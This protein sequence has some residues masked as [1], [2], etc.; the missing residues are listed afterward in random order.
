MIFGQQHIEKK[1]YA[2]GNVSQKG[3]D[4]N[5]FVHDITF[6]KGVEIVI[7][8]NFCMI[9]SRVKEQT[10]VYFV[11]VKCESEKFKDKT[12]FMDC[13]LNCVLAKKVKNC[14]VTPS[15][16]IYAIGKREKVINPE[17]IIDGKYAGAI[18]ELGLF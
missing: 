9:D 5:K 16:K 18:E 1:I 4:G 6:D 13:N 7:I 8:R 12:T 2:D 17:L 11:G 14:V 15:G 3:G 10:K